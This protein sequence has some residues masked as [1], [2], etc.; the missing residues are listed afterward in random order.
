MKASSMGFSV[1][2]ISGLA[3]RMKAIKAK[4]A[5]K[6]TSLTRTM[7]QCSRSHPISS[8]LR[9][10]TAQA[11]SAGRTSIARRS[12]PELFWT[13]PKEPSSQKT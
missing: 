1:P 9:A 4:A 5:R 10:A 2:M 6:R 3:E 11:L 13:K 12:P 7:R 8:S